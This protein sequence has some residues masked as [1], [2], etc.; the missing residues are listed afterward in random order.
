ML[1][2]EIYRESMGLEKSPRYIFNRIYQ[3]LGK[4][5]N[6]NLKYGHFLKI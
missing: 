4:N 5:L 3:N 6:K 2:Q 1:N